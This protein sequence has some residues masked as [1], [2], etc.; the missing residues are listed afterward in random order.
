MIDQK[1]LIKIAEHIDGCAF[2]KKD[3]SSLTS[4]EKDECVEYWIEYLLV[5][6]RL[7]AVERVKQG[8]RSIFIGTSQNSCV[9]FNI[10]DPMNE[11]IYN[12]LTKE[13]LNRGFKY[14]HLADGL[15][16]SWEDENES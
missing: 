11:K 5:R 4:F 14:F 16:I 3:L 13:L 8:R 2:N 7:A 1:Q 9:R 12:G 15:A 6:S 10:L